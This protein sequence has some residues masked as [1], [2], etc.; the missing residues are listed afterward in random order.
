ME[1]S[2]EFT[3]FLHDPPSAD[4]AD[5][6]LHVARA[7]QLSW[8]VNWLLFA[9]KV[10]AF[11]V[12]SSKAVLASMADSAGKL[13]TFDHLREGA[14]AKLREAAGQAGKPIKL[15]LA[16]RQ[17]GPQGSGHAEPLCSTA[18]RGS[19]SSSSYRLPTSTAAQQG[20]AGCRQAQL[21][22]AGRTC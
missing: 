10:Y 9:L 6:S 22:Q 13:A 16:G 4:D 5:H 7:F 19:G 21:F 15:R 14:I 20:R 17:P 12:S 1:E 18:L 8:V 3:A 11:A 2:G